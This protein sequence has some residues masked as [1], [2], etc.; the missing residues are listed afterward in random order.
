MSGRIVTSLAAVLA[1]L[2]A[3]ADA[4]T[5]THSAAGSWRLLPPAPVAIVGGNP[6]GVWTGRTVVVF[7]RRVVTK[8]DAN[9]APYTVR[10]LDAAAA[11][12]PAARRWTRLAPPA[13][14]GYVPAYRVLWT[15]KRLLA[16]GAFHSVAYDPG[17]DAWRALP[18]PINLGFAA[19]TG[20]QAIGWGG[21]CCGDAQ[22]NG[23]AYDPATGVF[24]NLPRS[25]LA[26]SQG[27][28][29][30]WTGTELI[31]F[32]S[33]YDPDGKAVRGAARAAAYDPATNRW[34][35]IA[36][37]PLRGVPMG[38]A[39]WDGHELLVVGAGS[40]AR[41]AFAYDPAADRWRRLASLPSARV[42]GIAVWA[43]RRLLL[44]GGED[45]SGTRNLRDGLAY[46][47]DTN[48]WTPLPAAPIRDFYGAT[49]T[50]TGR[51]LVVTRGARATAYTP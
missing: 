28:L 13:G 17:A 14:P 30:A 35:R 21:G 26:P 49:A 44:L 5:S 33:G 39:A 23:V 41:A 24:R 16:F 25:P 42:G 3:A 36:P 45:R 1:T 22:S 27:P 51:M 50:W 43:G 19:W 37:L 15:G 18:R 4:G 9:G 20:R 46:D 34:H 10:S 32:V 48:R 8:L 40:D 2:P 29:G 47:P 11:Y 6:T 31:L 7:G 12:D 38:V